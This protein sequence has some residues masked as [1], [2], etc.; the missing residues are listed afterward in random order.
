M[1][2][3]DELIVQG[4][5]NT[6]QQS[7][8]RAASGVAAGSLSNLVGS[9]M[10]SGLTYGPS[11]SAEVAKLQ[12]QMPQ[13]A[14]PTPAPAPATPP[15]FGTVA[16][17]TVMGAA[18]SGTAGALGQALSAAGPTPPSGDSQTPKNDPTD[19]GNTVAPLTVTAKPLPAAGV[20]P[21]ALLLPAGAAGAALLASGG[22]GGGGAAAD[23][24]NTVAPVTVT[25]N[26]LPTPPPLANAGAAGA[27]AVTGAGLADPGNTV[28]GVTVQAKPLPDAAP[29]GG[30]GVD[31]ALLASLAGGAA[32]GAAAGT[33]GRGGIMGTGVDGKDLVAGGL[34]AGSLLSGQGGGGGG[35]GNPAESLSHLAD[36]NS[37]L[38][39]RLGN[40]SSSG[41]AG[42]IGG[43]GLNSIDRMV[44]KAQASIRQ[45]YASMG[46]SGSTA[47][48]QDLQAAADSGVD[49]QFKVGQEMAQTGLNAIAALTGQSASI[50]TALMNAQ[51][52]KD[53]ALGNSLA[54]FAA[55]LVK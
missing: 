34:L 1:P 43:R 8:A 18:P 9:G 13:N 19:Q 44:R 4:V 15:D 42:D 39:D 33:G 20:N 2:L 24:G 55:A 21:A 5:R 14:T 49:L 6:L 16:P 10:F 37:A 17:L 46:M 52:A 27:G 3:L 38:A 53:T 26:P 25:A 48:M 11:L 45:R 22:G 30:G 54:N 36:N 23:V 40:I 47:E 51:T 32:F 12:S 35:G 7:L 50:Y 31:P 28:E 29:A 41:F